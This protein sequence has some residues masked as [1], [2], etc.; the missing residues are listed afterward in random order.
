MVW[1]LYALYMF[2]VINNLL[3][4]IYP[5][6]YFFMTGYQLFD[7]CILRL[8]WFHCTH[9]KPW[10]LRYLWSQ[11]PWRW[12]YRRCVGQL[13]YL[14]AFVYP[15]RADRMESYLSWHCVYQKSYWASNGLVNILLI[16]D[17]D[18]AT[19]LFSSMILYSA[20]FWAGSLLTPR[21]LNLSPLIFCSNDI[22]WD[23]PPCYWN[24]LYFDS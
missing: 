19:S 15:V 20:S 7:C 11:D 12:I 21:T 3:G 2:S 16:L 1:S 23:C 18:L 8:C 6:K 24:R 9:G 5:K 13:Q 17:K 4:R 22:F 14:W 10:R